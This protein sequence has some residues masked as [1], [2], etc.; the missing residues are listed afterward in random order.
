[1]KYFVLAGEASGDK[2]AALLCRGI[3]ERDPDA[4]IQGWGGEDMEAAGAF[5]TKHYSDLAFMGF[6]EVVKHLRTIM[7]NFKAC[8]AEIEAFEPDALILVDYPGFN[9]RMARWAHKAGITTYYYISPQLWAWHTSRVHSIKRVIRKMYVILP[10]E[11]EF[12]RQFDMDVMYIGHPLAIEMA[13]HDN[14]RLAPKKNHIGLLPGSRSH[15]V[16]RLLPEMMRLV[17]MMPGYTFSIAGV[18]HLPKA[19]YEA[20]IGNARNVELVI[21]NMRRVLE[22][23]EAAIVTSGTA[24]L[25]TALLDVPQVVVYKGSPLSYQIARRLIKVKYISLV[26]LIADKLLVKELIQSACTAEN[27][28]E[29]LLE[30]QSEQAHEAVKSG[31]ALL[32]QLLSSGGGAASA[33]HDIYSDLHLQKSQHGQVSS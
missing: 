18:P 15:E 32:R 33:A 13:T 22:D 10:F 17:S 28:K 27:M 6:A 8:K 3:M 1:L 12:Y 26:N 2:Q 16:E 11:T 7:R 9:L 23:S 14:E 19:L 5:V 25:E 31:Y 29:A 4:V 30:L 24:T 21:G 20:H